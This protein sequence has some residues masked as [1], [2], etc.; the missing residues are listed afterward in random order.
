[1]A[2]EFNIYLTKFNIKCRYIHSDIDTLERIEIIHELKEGKIDVLIGV[3]LLREGLD[4]PEVSLVAIMDAD[5]EGFLRSET[6]LTQTAGRVARNINGRVIMYA[7]NI[8]TSMQK[9]IDETKR[10][11]R[12][13]EHFNKKQGIVP[14]PLIK[15][16]EDIIIKSLNP[17][18]TTQ[19]HSSNVN[20]SSLEELKEMAIKT[21]R[22]MT[23]M[24]K[25]LNFIE[26]N[27]LKEK[28]RKIEENIKKRSKK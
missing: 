27:K 1:M 9:T 13:Q 18:K 20:K 23:K 8:T 17:Y 21:K 16:E 4:L 7:E 2:E 24:A 15:K 22:E 28:L 10:R 6:A 14:Q 5:K 25:C 19:N 3:N 12:K 11:R 26:A